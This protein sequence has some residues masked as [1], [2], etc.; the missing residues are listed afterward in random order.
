MALTAATAAIANPTGAI[1][2]YRN[3]PAREEDAAAPPPTS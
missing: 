1:T 3:S 2:V